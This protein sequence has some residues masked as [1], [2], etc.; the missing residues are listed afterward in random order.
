MG[1]KMKE[2]IAEVIELG[3]RKYEWMNRPMCDEGFE[4]LRDEPSEAQHEY[5]L[6]VEQE[7][8]EWRARMS[9]PVES[10][11]PS[12]PAEL[13]VELVKYAEMSLFGCASDVKDHVDWPSLRRKL[14]AWA[15]RAGSETIE[16][17]ELVTLDQVAPLTGVTKRTLEGHLSA[18]R[19]PKP[20][21][22]GSGGTAHKW[23]WHNL[24]PSLA[25]VS[26][27]ILP[28]KFPGSRILPTT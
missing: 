11:A 12:L 7:D 16:L 14:Q 21:I 24:R 25:K 1:E 28:E 17:S 10:L 6:R 18:E 8:R 27:N 2:K 20:D 9:E 13:E 15:R 3:D 5:N 4:N 19:L 22:K 26:K 23:Y